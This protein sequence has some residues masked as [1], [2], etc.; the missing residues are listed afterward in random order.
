MLSITAG[1]ITAVI[2]GDLIFYSV[3]SFIGG[4]N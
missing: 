1:F 3:F 2:F 4:L